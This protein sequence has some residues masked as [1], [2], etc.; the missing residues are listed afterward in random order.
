MSTPFWKPEYDRRLQEAVEHFWRTRKGQGDKQ[1]ER[2]VSDTGNRGQVTGGKQMD[3]FAELLR[4]I[5][6]AVGIQRSWIYTDM[7]ELPGYFR[8][9]KQWD[10]LIVSDE[11]KLVCC[12]EL[13]SHIGPSFGNNFNNRVEEALGSAVDI[14][15]AYDNDVFGKQDPFWAGYVMLLDKSPGSTKMIG[16][17]EPHFRVLKEFNGASYLGRY[18]IFC[19]RLLQER[20]YNAACLI[21]SSYNDGKPTTEM[22]DPAL[23]FKTFASKFRGFLIGEKG[24]AP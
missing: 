4:D 1:R 14:H 6:I 20:H 24:A 8:P 10:F 5:A 11:H 12:V 7:D 9:T 17:A 16:V 2:K 21:A 3:C 15:S 18:V 19:Q 22:P 23:S 13:K